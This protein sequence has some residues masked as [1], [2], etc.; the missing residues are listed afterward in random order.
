MKSEN[1]KD[2]LKNF[3]KFINYDKKLGKLAAEVKRQYALNDRLHYALKKDMNRIFFR[4]TMLKKHGK[5]LLDNA[6]KMISLLSEED[7]IFE[8]QE[9]IIDDI[10]R[11]AEKMSFIVEK[12]KKNMA[13]RLGYLLKRK[14]DL[15]KQ[16]IKAQIESFDLDKKL[17]KCAIK[18]GKG[19]MSIE[20]FKDEYHSSSKKAE[21]FALMIGKDDD[22]LREL[23]ND[24]AVLVRKYEEIAN[25]LK[26]SI[27]IKGLE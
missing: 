26:K 20:N 14:N 27:D 16:G 13:L 15:L 23:Y 10:K 8:S 17:G 25:L 19:L 12:N 4:D 3:E 11:A 24:A 2:F 22:V 5:D 9:K 7:L 18:C 1:E 21:N 6:N